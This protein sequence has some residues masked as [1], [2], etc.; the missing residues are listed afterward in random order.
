MELYVQ[1]WKCSSC[2]LKRTLRV[3]EDPNT[4]CDPCPANT[5]TR[6]H[7]WYTVGNP[8]RYC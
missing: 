5:I 3:G 1:D 4:G 6:K 2:G 8:R 7:A